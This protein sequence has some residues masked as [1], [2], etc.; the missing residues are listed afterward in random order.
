MDLTRSSVVAAGRGD[1]MPGTQVSIVVRHSCGHDAIRMVKTFNPTKRM[2]Q[3][4]LDPEY[5]EGM[6]APKAMQDKAKALMEQEVPRCREYWSKQDC[7]DC[8][9]K[10]LG[11]PPGQRRVVAPRLW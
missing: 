10:N 3:T 8:Y 7:P 1:E 11:T 5:L 2:Y 6:A 9:K 4:I